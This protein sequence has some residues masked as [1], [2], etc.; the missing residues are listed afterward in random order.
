MKNKRPERRGSKPFM[1]ARSW[2]TTRDPWRGIIRTSFG[3]DYP[4]P[5]KVS[6]RSAVGARSHAKGKLMELNSYDEN[7]NPIYGYDGKI[8]S[9]RMS[10]W[11]SIWLTGTVVVQRIVRTTLCTLPVTSEFLSLGVKS[12]RD[13]VYPPCVTFCL[14]LYCIKQKSTGLSLSESSPHERSITANDKLTCCAELLCSA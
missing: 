2:K 11:A 5:L 14:A 8:G 12:W 1:S 10:V 6:S 7:D 4:K 13:S 3:L 9:V